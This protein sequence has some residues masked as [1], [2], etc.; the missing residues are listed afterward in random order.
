M[1]ITSYVYKFLDKQQKKKFRFLFF[2]SI[3]AMIFETLT[4]ASLL[5]LVASIVN[6]NNFNFLTDL[7]SHFKY[8]ELSPNFFFIIL[9][10]VFTIKTFFLIYYNHIKLKFIENVKV[11]Q[12]NNLFLYYLNKPYIFHTKNNSSKLIRNL[13]EAQALGYIVRSVI[14]LILETL[15]LIGI[16]IFLFFLNF[17]ITLLAFLIFGVLG[18]TFQVFILKK[19]R[20]WGEERQKYAGLKIKTLQ[21][22]FGALKDIFVLNKEDFF[23]QSFASKNQNESKFNYRQSLVITLPKYLFEW[24]ALILIVFFLFYIQL[25]EK[26]IILYIPLISTFALATY[27]VVP[28]I[29]KIIQAYQGLKY[30]LPITKPYIERSLNFKNSKKITKKK[31]NNDEISKIN[32]GKKYNIK[33]KNLTFGYQKNNPTLKGIN[34]LI[35]SNSLIGF[36]GESGSGKTTLVNLLI[37]L[38]KPDSGNILFNNMNVSKNIKKWLNIISYV[39]QNVYIIDDS[40]SN[41][42]AFGHS[43]KNQ[44]HNKIIK[45]LKQVHLYNFIK[46]LKNGLNTNCGELGDLLSG[47]QKQRLA[48]ARAFYNDSKILIFDEF[49]NFLDK[50][51]ESLIL[52]DVKNMKNK[53]RI[54][55]SH[56]LKVLKRCDYVYKLVNKKLVKIKNL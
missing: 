29:V 14:E 19:V 39:P 33:I 50:K 3:L 4:L 21:Q 46:S 23:K 2:L 30:W 1:N 55:I 38:L 26:N 56:D 27:R 24:I 9:F 53:T 54:I 18:L 7:F 11:D 43:E 42:I 51:N 36:Y 35:K 6:S 32:I 45:S 12:S 25:E 37:G 47:G 40:I 22:G 20:F 5:P 34:L 52:N 28:S 15:V 49:T 48:I 13:N 31:N 41:N 16:C 8:E 10:S 17:K 44:N